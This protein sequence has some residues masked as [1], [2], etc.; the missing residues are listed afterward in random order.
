MSWEGDAPISTTPADNEKANP[1]RKQTKLI[2]VKGIISYPKIVCYLS[3]LWFK[4][5]VLMMV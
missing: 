3:L 2:L 4:E 1:L 5:E